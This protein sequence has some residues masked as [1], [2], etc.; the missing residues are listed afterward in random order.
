MRTRPGLHDSF[1]VLDF[2]VESSQ[3]CFMKTQIK[4]VILFASLCIVNSA[5]ADRGAIALPT[6][7]VQAGAPGASAAEVNS[8][9]QEIMM[10]KNDL[11]TVKMNATNLKPG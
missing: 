3:T 11:A 8:L 9:K 1:G 4:L 2:Y 7:P 6:A 5:W 10:L